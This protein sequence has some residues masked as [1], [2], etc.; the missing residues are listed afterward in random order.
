MRSKTHNALRLLVVLAFVCTLVGTLTLSASATS[1]AVSASTGQVGQIITVSVSD[2]PTGL[3]ISV[4]FDAGALTTTPADVVTGTTGTAVCTVAI[5]ASPAG[6]HT[7]TVYVAGAPSEGTFVV[8]PSISISP[9]RGTVGTAVTLVGNGFTPGTSAGV[10]VATGELIAPSLLPSGVSVIVQPDGSFNVTG[11]IPDVGAGTYAITASDKAGNTVTKAAALTIDPLLTITP[12]HAM[13]GKNVTVT[14]SGWPTSGNVD[15][16]IGGTATSNF[17]A[18]VTAD[19]SGKLNQIVT[20]KPSVTPGTW[21]VAGIGGTPPNEVIASA[22]FTVDPRVLIMTP[23]QGPIGTKV[24]VTGNDFTPD[25][26]VSFFWTS[27]TI[28]WGAAT[29]DSNGA[30]SPTTLYIP[31]TGTKTGAANLAIAV[32]YGAD[33]ILQVLG[34]DDLFGYWQFMVTKPTMAVSP[35]TG[36]VGSAVTITGSGW[37]PNSDVTV[38]FYSTTKTVTADSKGDIALA[39]SVPVSATPGTTGDAVK[40]Q[41]AVGNVAESVSFTLPGPTI[42]VSPA[43]GTWLSEVTISG[44]G[45]NRY[46]SIEIDINGF[47]FPGSLLTDVLGNFQ[48]TRTVPGVAP[49]S[50]VITATD[51]V[52]TATTFFVVSEAA[53]TVETALA[54]ISSKLV[55]VWEYYNGTWKMYDPADPVGS[56]LETLTPGRGYWINVNAATELIYKGFKYSLV[57]GWNNVGWR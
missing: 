44:S 24:V 45:F 14:G 16:Y 6:E 4:R 20:M 11:A 21:Q 12:N 33:G 57:A 28:Y 39:T 25:R 13:S 38:N 40:A 52:S 26:D 7:L 32:D 23:L 50:A 27:P 48:V 8:T 15:L 42:S 18:T 34:G 37:V 29:T 2:A 43:E 41:D 31:A 22:F 49:G 55:R 9:I 3:P 46:S 36:A 53:E 56:D 1:V 47:I 35:T 5:P 10:S 19:A 17:W 30:I 54:G 51:G